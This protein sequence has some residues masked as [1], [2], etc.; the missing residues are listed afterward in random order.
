MKTSSWVIRIKA[1]KEVLFETFN[2]K[3]PKALNT[4]RY[5]AVPISEYLVSLN[6]P[7]AAKA[8]S[9]SLSMRDVKT[10][11]RPK[12]KAAATGGMFGFHFAF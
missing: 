6:N 2:P 11:W 3:I 10:T 5:E 1:T 9:S 12:A 7:I 4:E 8:G